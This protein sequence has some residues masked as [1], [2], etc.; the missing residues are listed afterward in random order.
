MGRRPDADRL[1]RYGEL[2]PEYPDGLRASQLARLLGVPRSTVMRDLPALEEEGI[3]LMEDEQ[4]RLS[5]FRII[6][7]E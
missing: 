7:D 3:L 2:I 5:L 1:Q 4:G 6:P